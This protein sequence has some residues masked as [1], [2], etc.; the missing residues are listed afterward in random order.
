MN[1]GENLDNVVEINSYSTFGEDGKAYAG[2]D[3]DS[4][5]GNAKPGD[6]TTYEDDTDSSPSL[7]LEIADARELAGTVFLDETNM[8]EL[9]TNKER[10]GNG[11]Y[12]E[13]EKG[14]ASVE[15]TL[16]ENTGSE[17]VYT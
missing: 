10:R 14:I 6:K 11:K 5:P 12:D 17:K 9:Q 4:N 13:G 3:V 1:N 15:V 8:P 16:T 2:I 7:Q